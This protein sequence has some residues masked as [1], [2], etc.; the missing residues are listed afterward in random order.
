MFQIA[1]KSNGR[2]VGKHLNWIN[3]RFRVPQASAGEPLLVCLTP[4]LRG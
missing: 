1:S 4:R 2:E 3:H